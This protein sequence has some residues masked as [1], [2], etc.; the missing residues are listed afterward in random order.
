MKKYET[1]LYYANPLIL[2][3]IGLSIIAENWMLEK[4]RV[5]ET[6]ILLY[7]HWFLVWI[8]HCFESKKI[9]G[10]FILLKIIYIIVA[11][12]VFKYEVTVFLYITSLISNLSF[13]VICMVISTMVRVFL[14]TIQK[15]KELTNTIKEILQVIPEPILIQWTNQKTK[16]NIIKFANDSAQKKMFNGLNAIP[17]YLD[18]SS[19]DFKI[20]DSSLEDFKSNNDHSHE[21]IS[22]SSILNHHQNQ[23]KFHRVTK[24]F[25]SSIETVSNSRENSE[26]VQGSFQI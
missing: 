23:F 1:F 7:F 5:Y 15:N 26:N 10:T 20:T 2:F 16:R 25:T 4:F 14:E 9:I 18:E 8:V 24:E 6:W 13:W 22:I 12:I 21:E 17:K 3:L 19:F 11:N